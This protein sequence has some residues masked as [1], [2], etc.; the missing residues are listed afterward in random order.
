MARYSEV[1]GMQAETVK[2]V[3]P[4]GEVF[5]GSTGTT[6]VTPDTFY[7]Q[8]RSHND[9]RIITSVPR[10][11]VPLGEMVDTVIAKNKRKPGANEPEFNSSI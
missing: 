11:R 9:S 3:G 8:M 2:A 7:G 10:R 4:W 5:T 6:S 1:M